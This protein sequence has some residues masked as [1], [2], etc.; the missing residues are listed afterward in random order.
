MI[1]PDFAQVENIL[2]DS[3]C[4]YHSKMLQKENLENF[5]LM[6]AETA[7]ESLA[8]FQHYSS[9]EKIFKVYKKDSPDNFKPFLLQRLQKYVVSNFNHQ[10]SE[11]QKFVTSE[12]KVQSLL[13]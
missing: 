6:H 7:F 9:L 1:S 11:I 3:K 5:G 13:F 8:K 2:L 10:N 4:F 12:F